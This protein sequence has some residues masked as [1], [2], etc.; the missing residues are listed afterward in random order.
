MTT[1]SIDDIVVGEK[2]G[3]AIFTV[4]LYAAS[5]ASVSVYWASDFAMA[6][7]SDFTDLSGSLTF[8][9]GETLKT[10]RIPIT[11]DTTAERAEIFTVELY[12]PANATIA[13]SVGTATIIDNDAPAG[14]PVVTVSDLVIDEA[15]GEASVVITLD[16]PSAS[17]VSMNYAT[18]NGSAV[19]GS[20]YLA[21]SGSISFAAGETAK[22]IKI[23]IVNDTAA[24][25]S[26]AF[27]LQLSDIANALLADQAGM[28]TIAR[29]DH[30]T[31]TT[32]TLTIS[33]VVV[34][35]S[36]VF[37][38]F[39]VRLSAPSTSTVSVYWGS[40]YDTAGSSDIYDLSG[41]LTFSPGEMLKTVR[42]PI[43]DD[44]TVE[45]L[46]SFSV[47]IYSPSNATVGDPVG[48]AT[49]IDNDGTTPATSTTF[50][51]TSADDWLEGTMLDDTI[52]GG[53]GDD[54]L[55]GNDGAD[56][57]NGGAGHDMIDGGS[58]NDAMTGGSGDDI[59][60]VEDSGDV[61]TESANAGMD[62]VVS[63]VASYALT[64]NVENL[65]GILSTGQI[66]TGNGLANIIEG[67]RGADTIDGGAGADSMAG[68]LGDDIYY[69][70]DAGDIVAE[71]S[72]QGTDSIYSSVSYTLAGRA[73]EQL[74]LS[75]TGNIDAVG[76]TLA[77][78]LT[79]NSGNN[80]LDGGSGADRMEG[81]GGNDI[82][83]VDNVADIVTELVGQ[84][85]DAVRTALSAYTLAA[86]VENLVGTSSAG[87][88]L[89]GNVLANNIV[90]SSGADTLDGGAGA[91]T[92]AGGLG[93]DVYYVDNSRDIVTEA[94]G[95]GRDAIYSTV[96]YS[97]SGRHIET[98]T[99]TGS[100]NVNATGNSLDNGLTGNSG[101]NVLNGG[102]GIDIMTGGLGD[103]IYYVDNI[104]DRVVEA[105]GQGN[106][107]IYSS[108]SYSLGGRN[109]E[110]MILTGATN[111]SATG[112]SYDN[113]LTGNSGNNVLNG[114]GGADILTGGLGDDIYYVDNSA[115][116]V[117]ESSGQGNDIVYSSV[118]YSLGGR[119]VEQLILTGTANSN[120]TGNSYDNILTGNSGNNVL[121]GGGGADILTGGG[122]QDEFRFSTSLAASNVDAITDFSVEADSIRL[123][124]AIFAAAGP[125]GILDSNAFA[126]G[127][128]ASDADDRI[129]YDNVNGRLLYDAD[130]SGSGAAVL[131]AT[132]G[133]GLSLTNMDFMIG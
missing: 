25:G 60:V 99:L 16:R 15:S 103:D 88:M 83:V 14:T 28:V 107:M 38:T 64:A 72:G 46:E 94:S 18:V 8:A 36:G 24:E 131:F 119:N 23:G 37:A 91:D 125:I 9:P 41:Y 45:A 73:V 110:Q 4:R 85:L 123:S 97:L 118:S 90:G 108:V 130:G 39:T 89:T 121:N 50:S 65:T 26:E 3:F 67:G 104:G 10:I 32:P 132:I 54:T 100:A 102:V 133:T 96:S 13:K 30:A 113:I 98:L 55:L 78:T 62:R 84:G 5:T 1:L 11:N 75:G 114:G 56:E 48:V 29:N 17:T 22:T 35:E 58:G 127:S 63:A 111:I 93:D 53:D 120:A 79:G 129:I 33:D 115:D 68:G 21:T 71:A 52:G 34:V 40:Y 19:A 126:V 124:S 106:D 77:N 57:L 70:D 12:S 128:T 82:Y 80:V 44:I 112:N 7:S 51:G 86:N 109:V 66:L 101:N 47:E 81:G 6:G 116:V 74:T 61:V 105:A 49:I 95:Q 87:Q 122:G 59:Y 20:D 43:T 69:V 117:V 31:V 92:L 2:D 76:N 27:L 42:I